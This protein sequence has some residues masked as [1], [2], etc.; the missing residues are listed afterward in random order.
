MP[1]HSSTT[2]LVTGASGYIA[3][4]CVLQLLQQGYKV[5]GTVR[6][7]SREGKIR[8]NLAKYIEANDRL[9]FVQADLSKDAGWD[10]A[11]RGCQ[12]VLHVASPFPS[13]QAKNEDDLIIPAREGTLRVLRAASEAGIKR[14][15]QT[16]S[17]AAIFEGYGPEGRIFDENDWSNL[18]GKI[19][20]YSKSKTL[21]ERAAWDFI[22]NLSGPNPLEL[23]VINP[24]FVLGPYLSPEISTSGQLHY[25]LLRHEV[26]GVPR[27][28]MHIVDVR[29]VAAAHI[30]AMTTPEAA[31]QRFC[32]V[33]PYVWAQD[34]AKML[35][36][37]YPTY[38]VPTRQI[39]DFVIRLIGIFDKVVALVVDEL[40]RKYS[41]STKRIEKTLNW[42][43]RPAKDT[44]LDM[45]KSMIE[46]GMIYPTSSH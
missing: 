34:I 19:S 7:L 24:G 18:D 11:M 26:P 10:A 16:S 43:P 29:D 32:C 38:H 40:G 2:V 25:K 45:A 37:Q 41:V 21:A 17:V 15:V 14:V 31:G 46:Q 20:A 12:Y 6:S 35:A 44:V 36:E 39:P 30:S 8:Q 28:R 9:E 13:A 27:A 23:A 5:R 3:M 4:H 1:D 33:A 42:H 22:K